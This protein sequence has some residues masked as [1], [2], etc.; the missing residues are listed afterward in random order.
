MF[1][2]YG[3]GTGKISGT[4]DFTSIRIIFEWLTVTSKEKIYTANLRPPEMSLRE[5]LLEGMEEETEIVSALIFNYK[6][7]LLT[8]K[9]IL[10][11]NRL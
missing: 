7:Y 10:I 6:L 4:E 3:N 1:D 11:F 9:E 8:K 2:Q 5:V